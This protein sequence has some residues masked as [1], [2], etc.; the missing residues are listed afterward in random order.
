[1][2]EKIEFLKKIQKFLV[3]KFLGTE[4]QSA[5]NFHTNHSN[6]GGSI[7]T[8]ICAYR[9]FQTSIFFTFGALSHRQNI[10]GPEDPP[11]TVIGLTASVALITTYINL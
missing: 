7:T 8:I 6:L 4:L 2:G 1:M 10:T 5:A 9:C 3:R 11:P